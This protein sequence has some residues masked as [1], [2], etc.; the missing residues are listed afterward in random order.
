MMTRPGESD[1]LAD[2]IRCAGYLINPVKY[3]IVPKGLERVRIM[4]HADNTDEQILD[5]VQVIVGWLK[6]RME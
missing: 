1:D 6:E 3:P 5:L 2:T 4:L